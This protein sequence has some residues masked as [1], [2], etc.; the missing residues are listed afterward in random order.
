MVQETI[1]EEEAQF[2]KTLKRGRIL[3]ERS[4]LSLRKDCKLFPG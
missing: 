1:D 4:I 2:L 3:F